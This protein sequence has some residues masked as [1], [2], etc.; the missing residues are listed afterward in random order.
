[1]V[2]G[3]PPQRFV[4]EPAD[5]FEL[6]FQEQ[7]CIDCNE[8][9]AKN[10][11]FLCSNFPLLLHL[12]IMKLLNLLGLLSVAGIL[13]L[14]WFV[15]FSSDDYCYKLELT[16]T[17]VLH[18]AWV[19]YMFRDGRRFSIASF[20]QLGLLKY[21]SPAFIAFCWAVCFIGA[22]IMVS[23][24]I[25]VENTHFSEKALS[26]SAISIVLVVMWTGLWRIVPDIIYWP[27][28]G[29]YSLLLLLALVWLY[30]FLRQLRSGEFTSKKI[31]FI[32]LLSF[33]CGNNSHNFITG[34]VAFCV[35][36]LG[37]QW[38]V[39]RN[40]KGT[41]YVL[42]AMAGLFGAA[43]L[44]FLAP[45]NFIRLDLLPHSG[46]S[47]KLIYYYLGVLAV[48]LYWVSA[49]L[50][51]SFFL[52][53]ISGA[54]ISFDSK[55]L[56]SRIR[57]MSGE[58]KDVRSIILIVHRHKYLFT[59]L[60]TM[61]VFAVAYRFA[62]ARTGVFFAIL[63]MIYIFQKGW[64][65]S[66]SGESK[67]SYYGKVCLLGVF[68]VFIGYEILQGFSL[69]EELEAREKVFASQQ[70]MDVV[71]SPIRPDDIPVAFTFT[72]ISPDSAHWVNVCV[73]RY[74]GLKTVRTDPD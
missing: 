37:Y 9:I 23:R 68:V 34:L 61:F 41:I 67:K 70:G 64:R 30:V 6:V 14:C 55:K 66:W 36:E 2:L 16:G 13:A 49:L 19:E 25:S 17:S 7:P 15:R 26:F 21:C 29:G 69:R 40:K 22:S 4:R 24:I 33:I 71:V 63:L 52:L 12:L 32:F 65:G 73:A 74:Y 35:I 53:W 58:L 45:G 72:D 46:F 59:A 48:H 60:A 20:L 28:G 31:I 44:V 51:L 38:V 42:S 8:H 57:A 18:V 54:K 5:A 62:A 27:T 3:D 10:G 47:Y 50:S 43:C 11:I 39:L 1:M 56:F